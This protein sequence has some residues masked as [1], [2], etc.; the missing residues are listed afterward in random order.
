MFD[1]L[2]LFCCTAKL[3]GWPLQLKTGTAVIFKL[4]LCLKIK[5]NRQSHIQLVYFLVQYHFVVS[6]LSPIF[7]LWG[8]HWWFCHFSICVLF[9][10][11]HLS[12]FPFFYIYLQYFCLGFDHDGFVFSLYQLLFI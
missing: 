8:W 11:V 6:N 1:S 4:R 10:S 2:V 12:I 3:V 5:A 9:V 7:L